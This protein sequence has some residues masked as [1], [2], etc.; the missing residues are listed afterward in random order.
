[1][2]GGRVL[3]VSGLRERERE[4][5]LNVSVVLIC[6]LLC[7]QTL[8]RSSFMT[9]LSRICEAEGHREREVPFFFSPPWFHESLDF[10][11]CHFSCSLFLPS[12]SLSPASGQPV[13]FSGW[14]SP[15][16]L[17]GLVKLCA[18]SP[19]PR[20]TGD[21]HGHLPSAVLLLSDQSSR[22]RDNKSRCTPLF[23][24]SQLPSL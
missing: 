19:S 14:L 20:V 23:A 22:R 18:Y 10:T 8:L 12:V 21:A 11:G 17:R 13:S 16:R 2:E 5:G 9:P 24:I 3:S 15:L 1:M 6:W 7:I 4:S